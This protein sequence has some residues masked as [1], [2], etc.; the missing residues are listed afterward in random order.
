VKT[1]MVRPGGSVQTAS[2]A[3][4]YLPPLPLTAEI[5]MEAPATARA[6]APAPAARVPVPTAAPARVAAA[7]AAA[8]VPPARPTQVHTGWIIQVG[9]YP[10]ETEAK[11]RLTTVKGKAGKL[12]GSTDAF[13]EPVQKS[14]PVLY[15][16][17]FAGLDKD[18]AEAACKFSQAQRCRLRNH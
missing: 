17:R 9:A 7:P 11:Q 6:E 4:L 8:P 5:G 16:A 18:R 1:L 13:T 10:A 14:G 12:L 3:P 2:I 15:R